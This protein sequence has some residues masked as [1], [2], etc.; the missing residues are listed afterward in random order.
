MNL[1]NWVFRNGT[2]LP[3]GHTSGLAISKTTELGSPGEEF[4]PSGRITLNR[5]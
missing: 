1:Q 3:L 2:Q 4:G 5:S